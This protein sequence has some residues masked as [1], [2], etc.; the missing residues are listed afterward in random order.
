MEEAGLSEEQVRM[1][2]DLRLSYAKVVRTSRYM[3]TKNADKLQFRV[4]SELASLR[5]RMMAGQLQLDGQG[6]HLLCLERMD[7]ISSERRGDSDDQ[8]GFLKGCMYDITDRCLHRFSRP[9]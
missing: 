2:V 1:A 8:S 9:A 5:A 3:T 6:F 7:A 4:K